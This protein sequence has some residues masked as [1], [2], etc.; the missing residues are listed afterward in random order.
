MTYKKRKVS[1]KKVKVN[2]SLTYLKK[3]DRVFIRLSN[4]K[5]KVES[6]STKILVYNRKT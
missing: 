2:N 5:T 6:N 3:R 1:Y 4:Y